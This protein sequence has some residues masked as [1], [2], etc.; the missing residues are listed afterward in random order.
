M[1]GIQLTGYGN[2]ADV[3]RLIDVPDVGPPG[4][5]EIIIDVEA[6]PVEP[7]DLYII[8]GIYGDLPPLPHIL[9]VE[10]VGRV[11]AVGRNFKHLKEGDRTLTPPFSPSW[12]NR[13]KTNASWLRSLPMEA[14]VNQLSMLG[15]NPATA[16]VLLTEVVPLKRGDWVIVNAANSSVGRAIIPIAKARG[17]RTVAIVRRADIVK[18]I[19]ALGGDVVLADG[20]DL[21]KRIAAATDKAPIELALDGVG[22]TATQALLDSVS[23]SG[24]VVAWSGM[25]GKPFTVSGPQLLFRNQT[26]RGFWIF[27]W[28]RAPSHDKLVAMYEELIPLMASGAISYPVAGVYSFERV[29]EALEVGGKLNGKAI[30]QCK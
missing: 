13:V 24:T 10:G 18:D 9:G 28:F 1:K 20:P 8:A 26:I 5:D 3:V 11:S 16:Y 6:A 2:P 4:P 19:Q 15:M 14:D 22:D 17:I 7:S 12:V 30:L 29:H 23:Y 25:S 27:N 21:A